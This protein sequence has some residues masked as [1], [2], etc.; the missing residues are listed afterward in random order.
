MD[1]RC[2]AMCGKCGSDGADRVWWLRMWLCP[3]CE[4]SR[5]RN[6]DDWRAWDYLMN[7][8]GVDQ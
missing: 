4:E 5:S 3:E 1:D 7:G 2:E 6:E 8:Y